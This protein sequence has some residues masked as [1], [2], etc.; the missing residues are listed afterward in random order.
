MDASPSGVPNLSAAAFDED[1]LVARKPLV[2]D[3][4]FDITAMVDLVFMMNIF[5]LV[6]W[7]TAALAEVDLPAAR[8]CVAADSDA[9]VVVTITKT[10]GDTPAVYL[11]D[12]KPGAEI[13]PGEIERRV[14]DA[15]EAGMHEKPIRKT[16]LIKA[17]K[18]VR[19]RDV[20]RIA[21]V[22]SAVK[23]TKLNLA[24]MEKE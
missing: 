4:R 23:G 15:V 24:V 17:E 16:V 12:A 1:L 19:L 9:S 8:H 7:I 5:F 14:G 6:T 3:A 20:A 11:G 10:A 21:N 2:D 13:S 22:A 18:E